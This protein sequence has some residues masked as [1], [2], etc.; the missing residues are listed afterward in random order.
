VRALTALGAAAAAGTVL[1][2][3]ARFVVAAGAPRAA[4]AL[5]AALGVAVCAGA[6]AG[7]A[8]SSNAL[9]RGVLTAAA[10]LAGAWCCAAV[11]GAPGLVGAAAVVAGAAAA[12]FG[13]ALLVRAFGAG[14]GHAAFAGAAPVAVL[15]AAVFAADPFVE[16]NAGGPGSLDRAYA[17]IVVNPLASIAADAGVDWQ[18]TRWM[19]DGP[20]PG[21]PGLSVIGQYYPSRPASPWAWAAAAAAAG[22]A[23][24]ATGAGLLA[25]RALGSGPC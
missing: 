12:S 18:R 10:A 2:L 8:S 23:A 7:S 5:F 14:E 4:A 11:A 15:A 20:A 6:G 13:A 3:A 21:T 17:V 22:F 9:R 19:Y 24:T 25:R 1:G 16:W